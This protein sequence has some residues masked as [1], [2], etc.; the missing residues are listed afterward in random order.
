MWVGEGWR[1]TPTWEPNRL[2]SG[3]PAGIEPAVPGGS[4]PFFGKSVFPRPAQ[5]F[6]ETKKQG[7]PG[8]APLGGISRSS[9]PSRD[10]LV[11]GSKEAAM[12]IRF[13]K[14]FLLLGVPAGMCPSSFPQSP[15]YKNPSLPAEARVKDLL[16]RMTLKEKVAQ[17]SFFYL[18]GEKSLEG[19]RGYARRDGIGNL[20]DLFRRLPLDAGARIVNAA[21]EILL[22]ESRLGIP[23]IFSNEALHG[24][25]AGNAT[26]FPQAIGLAATFDPILMERI[27]G[28]IGKEC[29]AR[30]IR[31]VLSPVVNIARDVRWGRVEETYGEDPFLTS[32]MGSAFC[33]ALK[34]QGVITTPKHF[35]AD[36]GDGGRDSNAVHFSSL[37]LHEIY[38]PGFQA[39]I[40]VG[41]ADSIMA[42]FDS[43]NGL[44][45][46]ADPW[47][48][49]D[50]LRGEMGFKGFVMSDAGSVGGILHLHHL[51]GTK[52]A[53][54]AMA[55]KAGLDVEL[56]RNGWFRDGTL[57]SAV[58]EG[59]V[60]MNVLD[61]AV[62][63]VLSVKFRY[64]IFEEPFGDPR[65]AAE[66]A[67]CPAH[68]ALALEAA[69]KC[70]V[71]LKNDKGTLPFGQDVKVLALTGPLA[72]RGR[73]GG[74]S[75][76]PENAVSLLDGLK[77]S[78]GKGVEILFEK[79]CSL[80]AGPG[81][82]EGIARAV[83]AARKADAV[84]VAVG[85]REGEGRDRSRLGLPGRQVELIQSVAALGK[86]VV[87]V[88]YA[89]SAVTMEGWLD[90]VGAVLDA[91]YPGEAGG[92]ALAETL[93]GK[94]RPG[95]RLPVTFPR[96][97]GQVPLY[98]N[99]KPSGR[100]YGY[101]DGKGTPLFPFG[102][103]L[104][105][106]TFKYSRL[107]IEP[108]RVRSG[109]PVK[110]TLTVENIGK[111]KS[112]EVVQLY[113]RDV[114]ASMARPLK[115]LKGFRRITLDPGKAERISF[116]LTPKDMSFL[117][118]SLHWVLEPGE[119]RVMVG[120]SSADIRLR[121][122]FFVE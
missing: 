78:A 111:V 88:L 38:L 6:G 90:K 73:L 8:A 75:R 11:S 54:V 47:L 82:K 118:R 71:L 94:N 76:F 37:L 22:K 106:T 29:R 81:D 97:V 12:I 21:Q 51:G 84:V 121:G 13:F 34:K 85:I 61:R 96:R 18:K 122:T 49:T 80:A 33:L 10:L 108:A 119:F 1:V 7:P 25:V 44:P 109:A 48:L 50:V 116:Y 42:A 65:K 66:I 63:R 101:C 87:V 64:G 35:V 110:V 23:A 74:Y 46:S 58:K 86:P 98:Y 93:F 92:I 56:H 70:L 27:A 30:G 31:Q 89:G 14:A 39:C 2:F 115:E 107:V 77:R 117:D 112:D 72:A 69:R 45:C 67:D 57:L 79:G 83:A 103:G 4:S 105:Y 15:P 26:S 24:L 59:M 60:P 113:L 17:L 53:A 9:L 62:G 16:G 52:K 102:H 55:L 120:A 28:V 91:W 40:R 20:H 104:S 5:T 19:V 3:L 100:G 95:G 43:V 41:G 99:Y 68:R 32:W 36:C 114:T